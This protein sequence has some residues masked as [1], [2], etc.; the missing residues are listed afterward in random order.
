MLINP[1]FEAN[2]VGTLAQNSVGAVGLIM[3]SFC[4]DDWVCNA[5]D[6]YHIVALL[7]TNARSGTNCVLLRLA[8]G[9]TIPNDS[10]FYQSALTS[11]SK[12]YV[13]I[14]DVIR[15]SAW[16]LPVSHA[17]WPAGFN[18]FYDV[19]LVFF[20]ASGNQIGQLFAESTNYFGSYGVVQTSIQVPPTIGGSVP[21]Y[22]RAQFLARAQNTGA[23]GF[24][25]G[26]TLYGDV[27][28]DDVKV[29]IQSTA[30]DLTPANSSGA[31]TNTASPLSQVGVTTQINIA[32]RTYQFPDG[33]QTYNAGS[34]NPG[35]FGTFFIF[36]DDPTY[37]GGSVTYQASANESDVY[38]A[39]GRIFSGKIVTTGGG[40]TLVT[41]GGTGGG[42][43][44]L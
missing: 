18:N 7:N 9:V 36:F 35:G 30:F 31:P 20:D 38:A 21:A 29:V 13:A 33:P 42:R 41:R 24:A 12:L 8:Q 3:N 34:V 37:S 23:A 17:A 22:C 16:I 44:S 10:A 1:G 4:G 11:V 5:V 27:L 19:G 15:V 43:L 26:A 2:A 32:S 14:G 40:A 28:I 39:N 6:P 25:T